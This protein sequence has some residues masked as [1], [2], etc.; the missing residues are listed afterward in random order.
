MPLLGL[1]ISQKGDFF[2]IA[3]SSIL[4]HAGSHLSLIT[5]LT[6]RYYYYSHFIDEETEVK[7]SSQ[8]C[9]TPSQMHLCSPTGGPPTFLPGILLGCHQ[10]A[11]SEALNGKLYHDWMGL[12]GRALSSCGAVPRYLAALALALGLWMASWGCKCLGPAA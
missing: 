2:L 11:G 4:L 12:E 8:A 10:L 5:V 1:E 7:E 3:S 6:S 9:V